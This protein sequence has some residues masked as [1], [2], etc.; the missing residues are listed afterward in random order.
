MFIYVHIY[1]YIQAT[2]H[3]IPDSYLDKVRNI[4]TEF[5]QLPIE[6]KKKYSRRS[7]RDGEGYGGDVIVSHK[8]VLDWSDRVVLKVLPE[9]ERRLQFWPETPTNIRYILLPN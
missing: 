9:D 1:I 7:D 6:Q 3:G 2:G 5:F 8:Q 4:A